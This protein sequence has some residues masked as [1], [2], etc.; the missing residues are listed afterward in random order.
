MVTNMELNTRRTLIKKFIP[1]YIPG[2]FESWG[3]DAEV[4]RYLP[5]FKRDWN[6]DE[7]THYLLN[8]Y[9]DEYNDQGVIQEK[10]NNEIIGYV[11]MNQE[12]NRSKSINVIISS[13]YWGH[14]YGREVLK[15]V[16]NSCKKA[17]LGSLYATCDSHNEAAKHILED[18]DFE[19]IDSIP[20]D[21]KDIDGKTGDEL[22]YE[23]EMIRVK[24]E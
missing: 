19:M 6:M 20:G 12:D 18:A 9:K 13:Q 7:F 11:N 5:G 16:A 2:M 24:Y 8:T 3:Q 4:G 17:G 23:L 21:R 15:A 1:E 14:G 22:L 10:D